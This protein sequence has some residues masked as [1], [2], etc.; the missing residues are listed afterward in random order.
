MTADFTERMLIRTPSGD[1]VPL[2]DSVT[3]QSRT[4]F[5]TI[6]RENGVQVISVTGDISE[7]DPAR[8]EAVL[9]ALRTDILP[10]IS[11]EHGVAFR[12]AGLA[13][14][15]D[16]F[17]QDATTGL[18]LTLAGIFLVLAWIFSSWTRPLVVMA[19]IPFGLVGAIHG[20]W[21][22]DVP[23]SIFSVIGLIGMTGIIINDSIV[24]VTTID[25]YAKTRGIYQAI[26][27]GVTDRLRA[28]L[29]TT[30]TTVLGLMPLLNEPS[31]QAQFLKPT[32]I[33][34]VYGLGFGVVLVLIIVPALMAMQHDVGSYTA[35]FRRG[36]RAALAGRGPRGPV[37]AAAGGTTT[38]FAALFG[39]AFVTGT[40]PTWAAALVGDEASAFSGAFTL[41]VAGTA[42]IA[43]TVYAL[44][45]L[46]YS[47]RTRAKTAEG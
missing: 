31:V 8:A 20:H 35:G 33:T 27:D 28:V 41:F 19:I 30:L 13:E 43:L 4:G 6:L 18:L 26:V 46:A 37:L 1:Y 22:H 38:L 11:E 12:L 17:R 10:R 36:W 39:P 5:S 45:A 2:A 16:D 44:S 14:Q 29:L 32:I 40:L 25:G 9:T 15:E 24:L 21:W 47:L 42:V 7:D 23:M 3:V 34:L